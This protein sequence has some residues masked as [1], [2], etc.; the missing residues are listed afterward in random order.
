MGPCPWIYEQDI[1]LF[2]IIFAVNEIRPISN[3]LL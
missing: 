1:M 3:V 2:I